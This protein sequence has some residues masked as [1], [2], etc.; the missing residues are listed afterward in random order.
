MAHT[1]PA[2]QRPRVPGLHQELSDLAPG[3]LQ[4]PCGVGTMAPCLQ[5]VDGGKQGEPFL[6]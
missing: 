2:D 3:F 5:N 1:G 6:G 4:Q